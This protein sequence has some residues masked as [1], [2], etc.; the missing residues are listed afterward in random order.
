MVSKLIATKGHQFSQ[1]SMAAA[2]RSIWSMIS[3]AAISRAATQLLRHKRVAF[4]GRSPKA[5]TPVPN[6]PVS[7]PQ[8]HDSGSD[9][10]YSFLESD[11]IFSVLVRMP[12]G[13]TLCVRLPLAGRVSDLKEK[14]RAREGIPPEEQ[15]LIF[16]G[17]QLNPSMPVHEAGLSA[18]S[19]VSLMLTVKGGTSKIPPQHAKPE[20]ALATQPHFPEHRFDGLTF[21]RYSERQKVQPK[22]PRAPSSAAAAAHESVDTASVKPPERDAHPSQGSPNA[23]SELR[24]RCSTSEIRYTSTGGDSSSGSGSYGNGSGSRSGRGSGGSGSGSGGG[25]DGGSGGGSSGGGSACGRY[26]VAATA[27]QG[28]GSV[29]LSE[30]SPPTAL[31]CCAA[32]SGCNGS[33][34]T[35]GCGGGGGG[36]GGCCGGSGSG[37]SLAEL[38]QALLWL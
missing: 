30:P 35:G 31:L 27:D 34:S 20:S 13:H 8:R 19:E 14:I 37:G 16:A 23:P 25:S 3:A 17:K 36:R 6:A 28:M 32:E 7:P 12:D 18:G 4:C 2:G 38:E 24:L 9:G 29:P 26:G 15:R 21:V 1:F 11:S 5:Q 10:A 22:D 33:S